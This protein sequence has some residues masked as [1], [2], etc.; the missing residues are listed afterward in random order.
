MY[1]VSVTDVNKIICKR[2]WLLKDIQSINQ[3]INQ[4]CF[5]QDQY[6]N[7]SWIYIY[8]TPKQAFERTAMV[9]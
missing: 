3:S 6:Y 9:T 7:K 2:G 8:N 4:K 5:I 1:F